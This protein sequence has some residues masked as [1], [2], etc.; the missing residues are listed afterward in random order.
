M[1]RFVVLTV[2]L[3]AVIGLVATNV[4]AEGAVLKGIKLGLSMANLKGADD[5]GFDTKTGLSGGVFVA[6]EVAPQLA[7]Q[8]EGLY[9]Q[10]GSKGSLGLITAKFKLDYFEIPM[11]LKYTIPT[12]GNVSPFFFAGPAL[13]L[14]IKGEITVEAGGQSASVDMANQKSTDFSF[15][16]GGGMDVATQSVTLVFDARYTIGLSQAFDDV[17]PFDFDALTAADDFPMAWEDGR[18]LDLKTGTI[19]LMAGVAF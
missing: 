15:V 2:T 12:E 18:G 19:T 13:A 4:S 10:K 3:L 5:E 11:L 9:T 14:N 6:V 7:F 8:V 16:L 17:A 1:K